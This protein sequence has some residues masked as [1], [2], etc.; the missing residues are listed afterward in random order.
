MRDEARYQQL[1]KKR[2][3]AGLSDEEANELGRLLA[4]RAGQE[5]SNA[6]G[7]GGLEPELD[8]APAGEAESGEAEGDDA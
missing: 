7:R 2:G 6:Q 5:Y 1:I 3:E 4:E 8:E